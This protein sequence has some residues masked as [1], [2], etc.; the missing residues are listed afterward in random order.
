MDPLMLLGSEYQF[1]HP[2]VVDQDEKD[3]DFGETHHV[4]MHGMQPASNKAQDSVKC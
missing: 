2:L 4:S 3:F 1:R